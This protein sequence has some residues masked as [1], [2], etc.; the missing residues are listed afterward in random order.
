M[1]KAFAIPGPVTTHPADELTQADCVHHVSVG[2]GSRVVAASVFAVQF[3][4]LLAGNN[5]LFTLPW[6][7]LELSKGRSAAPQHTC[8]FLMGRAE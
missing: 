5:L 2:A 3:A 7:F 4:F 8:V 1:P 6:D